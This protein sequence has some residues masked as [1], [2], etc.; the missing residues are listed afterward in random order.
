MIEISIDN[1]WKPRWNWPSF[2]S[3]FASQWTPTVAEELRKEAP[4]KTGHLRDSLIGEFEVGS[5]TMVMFFSDPVSYFPL[6]V[7]EGAPAHDIPNAFGWGPDFGIGGQFDGKFHP[8]FDPDDF[9]VKVWA[10]MEVAMTAA[11]RR[12]ISQEFV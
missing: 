5:A 1:G 6:V 4:V 10:T 8:G 11:L 9:P 7:R 3:R 12:A 2:A